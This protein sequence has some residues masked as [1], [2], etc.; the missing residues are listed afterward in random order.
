MA[1]PVLL[2]PLSQRGKLTL[3][4]DLPL[5]RAVAQSM[6]SVVEHAAGM[7]GVARRQP[8]RAVHEW[9]KSLRRARALLRLTRPVLDDPIR[10]SVNASLRTAQRAASSLRD[11]EALQL[12][13]RSLRKQ[14]GQTAAERRD[15]ATFGRSLRRGAP[16]AGRATSTLTAHKRRILAAADRFERALPPELDWPDVEKGLRDSY[17]RARKSLRRLR[18]SEA[19]EQFHDLRKAIKSLHYQAE[20]LASTGHRPA[21][22]LRKRLDELAETQGHVTDLLLLR[23]HA[24]DLPAL[25]SLI[26]RTIPPHRKAAI[27]LARQVLHAEPKGFANKLIPG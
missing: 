4:M 27:K 21:A 22:R 16:S 24:P 15:I 18:R 25:K 3:S 7:A 11:A 23:A 1:S 9:R 8:T 13:L 26:A 2:P 19:D 17:A 14:P 10:Q 20:L 12:A 5:A 6:S